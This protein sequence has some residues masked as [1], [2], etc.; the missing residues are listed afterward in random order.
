MVIMSNIYGCH[1]SSCRVTKTCKMLKSYV[2][3]DFLVTD[4]AEGEDSAIYTRLFAY[5]FF[6]EF[7]SLVLKETQL[8]LSLN[9]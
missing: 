7:I 1:K 4:C 6:P 3:R 8:E 2:R 5:I 9:F